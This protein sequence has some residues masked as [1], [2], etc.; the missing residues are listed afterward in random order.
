MIPEPIINKAKPKV[1]PKKDIRTLELAKLIELLTAHGEK[2]YRARQIY[3]WLWKKKAQSFDEMTNLSLAL[4]DYLKEHFVILPIAVDMSQKSNDGTIKFRFRLHDGHLVEGVLI[5]SPTLDRMTA[6][7]SSQVGCSLSCRFCATGLLKLKRNIH[8]AEIFDQVAI[9]NAHALENYGKPLSN[10]VYMGMGEPMLNYKNVVKSVELI[11]APIGLQM[12]PR[13]ITIS[14]A[15]I[16]KMIKKLADDG[17]KCNLALSLHAANDTKRSEI[18]A[19]NDSN[20]LEALKEAL[21]YY[22]EKTNRQVYY[23]YIVF[24]NF[25]DSLEDAKELLKFC[26]NVPCK[27]NLIEYNTVEGLDFMK[28][29]EDKLTTFQKYIQ[30]RGI[31][32]TVRRSRGKDIDAACGQLANK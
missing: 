18:M 16:A 24:N 8:Y 7:I 32:I 11:T 14:T 6:C 21:R 28:T 2:A 22:Y 15:G 25:N 30:D 26:Q 9:I 4:R 1:I 5:P 29:T 12:A 27:V 17:T 20:S 23:E 10:V 3:E 31:Y 19:I 13:R